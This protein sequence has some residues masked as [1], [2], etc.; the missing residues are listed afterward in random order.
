MTSRP[1]TADDI[2]AIAE[3][4]E[5][6]EIA[7]LGAPEESADELR[8]RIEG[9]GPLAEGSLLVVDAEEARGVGLRSR[10]D[11]MIFADPAVDAA[12]VYAELLDWFAAGSPA[13]LDALS[14]DGVL[15]A[16]LDRAGWRHHMSSFELFRAVDDSLHLAEPA[17]PDGITVRDF[18]V[19]EAEA[20]HHLIY[21]DAGWAEVPGHPHRDYEEWRGIFVTEHTVPDQQVL[22]WRGDRLVGVA[23]GRTWDDGTG[24]VSQLA[25]AKDE[26]GKGLGRALLLDAL[27]RRRNAGATSLGL[28]VEGENRG[29]L[30]LY[31]GVGLQ[32][33]REW[34]EYV[35]ATG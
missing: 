3:L 14:N 28:A 12:P 20:I 11:T 16:A 7:L 6:W 31:L 5:R 10:N 2:P 27:T 23:M 21:V 17:W 25:T 13:K 22:A 1:A 32:I 8:E 33:N 19:E 4:H 34:M 9:L 24:W 18:R 15:R 30:N 35:L 26:R 29:A